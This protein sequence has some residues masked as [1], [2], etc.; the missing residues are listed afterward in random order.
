MKSTQRTFPLPQETAPFPQVLERLLLRVPEGGPIEF[1]DSFRPVCTVDRQEPEVKNT[2]TT[3]SYSKTKRHSGRRWSYW[4]LALMLLAVMTPLGIFAFGIAK[5]RPTLGL[6]DLSGIAR[7][8]APQREG[9]TYSGILADLRWEKKTTEERMEA[10]HH[11]EAILARYRIRHL[12]LKGRGGLP[13]VTPVC[14][15]QICQ[16]VLAQRLEE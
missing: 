1:S 3:P 4:T 2:A 5:A 15:G 8:I 6:P 12:N 10:L 16:N 14:I 9:D 13:A 7:I 11:M